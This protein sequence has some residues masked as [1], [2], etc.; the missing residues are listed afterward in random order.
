MDGIRFIHTAD[1]HL[2]SHFQ[3]LSHLPK[4]L[5]SRIQESTFKA[6]ET[7]VDEAIHHHVDFMIIVGDLYD[8]EDRSIKAQARLRKQMLR[9]KNAGISAFITHG[10]HDHLSGN[11]LALELPDNVHIFKEEVEMIPF[12]TKDG[13]KVYLYGFSYP[14]RH[15]AEKKI[16]DYKKIDGADFHI[17]LLHGHWENGGSDHQPY[18]PFSIQELLKK[19]MDYWALGHI[20][21]RQTLH[22]EPYIVYPGNIQGIYRKE[23]LEKGCYTVNLY[24]SGAAQL[25]FIPVAPIKWEQ[26][27]IETKEDMTF[28]QFYHEFERQHDQR[29]RN[30]KQ[31]VLLEIHIEE[32]QKLPLEIVKKIDNGEFL[33]MLQDGITFDESFIWPYKI[34]RAGESQQS[35][36]ADRTFVNML[37]MSIDDVALNDQFEKALSS[38]YSHTYG[39]RYLTHISEQEK[40]ALIEDAKQLILKQLT[41]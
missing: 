35:H 31:G 25:D 10:N 15:V 14:E 41:V 8:G 30:E 40:Q 18:A 24:S 29:L 37:E 38:L 5:F 26:L 32:I 21:K 28:S 1:L 2:D 17:G 13:K 22:T 4:E 23:R 9:L 27:K 6:F 39:S 19:E 12:I 36:I 16:N 3:G 11:W 33:E 34:N 20:H 7:I